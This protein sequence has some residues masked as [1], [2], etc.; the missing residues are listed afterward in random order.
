METMKVGY[1][2]KRYPRYSE[3]FIVNEILAHERAGLDLEIFALGVSG[4][5]HFQGNIASVR[6]PVSYLTPLSKALQLWTELETTA[7]IWPGFWSEVG[8]G[9]HDVKEVYQALQL[10]RLTKDRGI[11]HLHA[12]FATSAASVARLAARLAGVPFTMTAHAKDIFHESVEPGAFRSKLLDAAVTVTVS[13]FNLAYLKSKYGSAAARVQRVYNGL[14]LSD[15]VYTDPDTRPLDVVAVGRLV[16]KKGFEDLVEALGILKQR[17]SPL[18]CLIIGEGPLEDQIRARIERLDVGDVVSM[19]GP[20]PQREVKA[21]VRSA[22]MFAAPCVVGEDGNRDG[23]PTV[24][25]EAMALGTPCVSTD[26]TGIP[27]VLSDRRTGLMVGQRDP[28]ALADA[29]Q[30]LAGDP[31]LRVRL[32]RQARRRIEHAFDIRRNAKRLRTIFWE[33]RS[34]HADAPAADGRLAQAS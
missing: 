34:M 13:D 4:D 11:T 1:V 8:G 9:N 30:E 22:A 10:A 32:A 2:V 21:R 28:A 18:R 16:E 33:C 25:L 24:L 12:H 29:L 7:A 3:T 23:L 19:A 26:V 27:E 15:F 5:T 20:C 17:N 31:A 14:D 6:A